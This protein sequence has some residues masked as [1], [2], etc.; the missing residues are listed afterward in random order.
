MTTPQESPKKSE[1][2]R[3]FD[4]IRREVIESRNLVIKTDNLLKSLH[5][6]LKTVSKRQEDFERR[7]LFSSAAAYVLLAGLC[8]GLSYF[9][10]SARGASEVAD[11]KRVEA[12]LT[13][14][15]TDLQKMQATQAAAARNKS[16]ALEVH[17]QL[18]QARGEQRLK[19]VEAYKALDAALL[20][21]LEKW[22]L[23]ERATAISQELGQSSFERGK[24]AFRRN[25]YS[26]AVQDLE[27]FLS[28]NPSVE[29]ALDAQFFLGAAYSQMRKPQQVIVHLG[30]F[31]ESDRKSK[32]RDYAMLLLSQAYEQTQQ[33]EKAIEVARAAIAAYPSSEFLPGLKAR[34]SAGKKS[35]EA[36]AGAPVPA[37]TKSPSPDAGAAA[38]PSTPAPTPALAKP[39]EGGAEKAP[40][41]GATPNPSPQ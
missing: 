5:A 25:E 1:A 37:P 18:L 8:L 20:S 33:F 34:L 12:Q 22:A 13:E 26:L 27:R 35:G 19:A 3:S 29:E 21:D 15:R 40:A 17:R 14:A 11:R 10:F 30:K 36:Q 9:Y 16:Q 7:T 6:E 38:A 39:A 2:E 32:T 24:A 28:L 4:E 23:S 31:V 41:E